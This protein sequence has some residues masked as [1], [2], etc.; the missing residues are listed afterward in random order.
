MKATWAEPEIVTRKGESG[1]AGRHVLRHPM[2]EA[3][4]ANFPLAEAEPAQPPAEQT[5]LFAMETN[6]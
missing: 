3:L 5:S 1:C 4:I 6:P 2:E